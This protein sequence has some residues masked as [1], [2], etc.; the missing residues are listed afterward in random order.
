MYKE[1][2]DKDSPNVEYN[3]AINQVISQKMFG[4]HEQ[5]TPGKEEILNI[6]GGLMY[7]Q[8]WRKQRNRA[9]QPAWG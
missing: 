8:Y 1:Y 2:S 4:L 5:V 7:Y 6:N 9:Y 3:I